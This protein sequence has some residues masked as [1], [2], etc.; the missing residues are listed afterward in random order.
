[1]CLLLWSVA[2]LCHGALDRAVQ[3]RSRHS[4]AAQALVPPFFAGESGVTTSYPEILWESSPQRLQVGME[5]FRADVGSG[6]CGDDPPADHAFD[7]LLAARRPWAVRSYGAM[8]APKGGLSAAAMPR[9][10]RCIADRDH[11][12]E[13]ERSGTTAT[14]ASMDS[15][16]PFVAPGV[17]Q[18]LDCGDL[19]CG[20]ARLWWPDL[21]QRPIV[22][23]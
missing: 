15:G 18:F 23:I 16:D 4:G 11:F 22:A 2:D 7:I 3:P 12:D 10:R 1:M 5:V 17:E 14:N 19:R 9:R 21:P 8:P 20:F 6:S 13:L